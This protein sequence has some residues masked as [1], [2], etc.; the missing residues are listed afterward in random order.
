MLHLKQD[1][2]ETKVLN[3]IKGWLNDPHI[4]RVALPDKWSPSKG[5]A[6]TVQG[7]GTTSTTSTMTT[8]LVR[9]CVYGNQ[10]QEVRDI[11]AEI[12]SNF[13]S[14]IYRLP[15]SRIT[16]Q[17]GILVAPSSFHGGF[18]ASVTLSVELLRLA[19]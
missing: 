14:R 18:V 10:R 17:R 2:A 4:A 3:I 7:D 9:V 11:I 8:E 1:D 15:G 13:A 16:T 5:V 6:I 12:E 19:M